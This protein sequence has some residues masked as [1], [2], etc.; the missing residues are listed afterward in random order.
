MDADFKLARLLGCGRVTSAQIRGDGNKLSP[1]WDK[2][3]SP[4]LNV[5]MPNWK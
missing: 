3:F 1:P 5:P 4:K 2:S